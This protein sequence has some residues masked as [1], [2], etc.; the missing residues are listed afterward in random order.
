[1]AA[2]PAGRNVVQKEAKIQ[3]LCI[4]IQRT[5]NMKCMIDHTGNKWSHRNNNKQ[6]NEKFGS[7]SRKTFS[8]LSTKDSST[9]NITCNMGSAAV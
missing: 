9:W 5:W 8:R 2:V 3:E 6:F 4:E 7:H 1:M